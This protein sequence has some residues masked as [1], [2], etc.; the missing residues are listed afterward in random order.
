MTAAAAACILAT[1]FAGTGVSASPVAPGDVVFED[2]AVAASL[3][4]MPGD[5]V[6]GAEIYAEKSVGNCVSCHA[7]STL[8]DVQFP[9]N[10]GPALD[11]AAD[12]YSEAQLRGIVTNAKMTFDGSMMPSFYKV[13]GFIRPGIGFTSKPIAPEDITPLL[14]PE[15]IEDVVAF[16]MTLKEQ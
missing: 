2:G 9:G 16:L 10:I 11:G 6:A 8:P 4:G 5:P 13:T 1:G 15:Q 3:T 12:R 14:T 7:V